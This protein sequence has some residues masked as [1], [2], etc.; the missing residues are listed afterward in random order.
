MLQRSDQ[1]SAPE[2]PLTNNPLSRKQCRCVRF[3]AWPG[4]VAAERE[5][6]HVLARTLDNRM[7]FELAANGPSRHGSLRAGV[8]FDPLRS[9]RVPLV[10][11]GW[12]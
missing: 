4:A 2:V 9:N 5:A 6:E 11:D 1:T 10:L 3:K 8:E 7:D 12:V